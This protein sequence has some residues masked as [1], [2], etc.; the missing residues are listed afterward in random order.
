[1]KK[2]LLCVI[3]KTGVQEYLAKKTFK[4]GM[5][6]RCFNRWDGSL[7]LSGPLLKR[8]QVATKWNSFSA[9]EQQLIQTA[10]HAGRQQDCIAYMRDVVQFYIKRHRFTFADEVHQCLQTDL[11]DLTFDHLHPL[12]ACTVEPIERLHKCF[13]A[14]LRVRRRTTSNGAYSVGP[15]NCYVRDQWLQRPDELRQI[16][17]QTKSTNVMKTLSKEWRENPALREQ[18]A[19]PKQKELSTQ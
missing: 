14:S 1:M 3:A 6:K 18:Y 17:L 12:Y 11:C 9:D 2:T 15:F 10:M 16:C 8:I 4:M 19:Q 13:Q 7:S 5:I